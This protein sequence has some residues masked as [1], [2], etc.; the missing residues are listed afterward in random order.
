MIVRQQAVA[1]ESPTQFLNIDVDIWS[2][3]KLEPLMA[4][5][6]KNVL[7]HYVGAERHEQSA[8]FSLASAHGKD[9]DTIL[10][11]LVALIERLPPPARQLWNR[12]RTRDF[13]IG[14][15]A[16]VTPFSHELALEAGTLERAAAVGGRVVITT[17]AAETPS[18][19]TRVPRAGATARKR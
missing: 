14:I 16:G 6:G 3:S 18:P 7:V 17:Y 12:A 15:Q 19:P 10:H 9:P 13:N 2:K 4:A 5:L 8:H 1:D 11:R